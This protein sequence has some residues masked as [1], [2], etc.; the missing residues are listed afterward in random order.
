MKA[1]DLFTKYLFL[2]LYSVLFSSIIFYMKKQI[3]NEQKNPFHKNVFKSSA[4]PILNTF[5]CIHN[6]Q[7]SNS[8][9]CTYSN[10][11][12]LF[13][14]ESN[15]NLQNTSKNLQNKQNIENASHDI[16]NQNYDFENRENKNEDEVSQMEFLNFDYNHPFLKNISNLSFRQLAFQ[17]KDV[18][19]HKLNEFDREALLRAFIHFDIMEPKVPINQSCRPEYA[20][21]TRCEDYP[22][23]FHGER[24]R[25]AKIAHMIQ[26]GF[27][28]DILEIHLNEFYDI[29]DKFFIVESARTHFLNTPKPFLWP[30]LVKQPRFAKFTEKVVHIPLTEDILKNQ[31][32]NPLNIFSNEHT[33]ERLRW[34]KFLEWN[35]QN[36]NYFNDDD[37]IGFGDTDEI[38]GRHNIE[39]LRKC[40]FNSHVDIGI[41]FTYGDISK[42]YKSDYPVKGHPYTL[43]DP[44]FWTL[45]SAKRSMAPSR[46]R[47]YS[48]N[49][50]LGG[51]HMTHYRYYPFLILKSLTES[52]AG[53][54]S[55]PFLLLIKGVKNGLPIDQIEKELFQDLQ[56]ENLNTDRISPVEEH[57]LG[58]DQ[59]I[60]PWFLKCNKERYP[61]YFSE[62]PH[63]TR[64][65]D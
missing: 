27:E 47:G 30:I 54:S 51:L 3:D 4:N 5:V 39:L 43:G 32:R 34:E 50:L 40:Q 61:L 37:V 63:D 28:T 29:I 16:L 44:T 25:P 14:S 41:W 36:G 12:N 64:L 59:Y 48:P 19:T 55:V 22:Q 23:T 38:A 33:Q 2:F 10:M 11:E 31:K 26:Y 42:K 45:K 57:E 56:N 17:L 21:S 7:E 58:H 65:N 49:Y 53:Y 35:E 6:H 15:Y 20:A 1:L 8:Y 13:L 18:K 46:M 9:F 60:M 52:E 62:Y 24:K